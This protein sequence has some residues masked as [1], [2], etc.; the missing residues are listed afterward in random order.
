MGKGMSMLWRTSETFS[1]NAAKERPQRRQYSGACLSGLTEPK[2][3]SQSLY[4]NPVDDWLTI[5]CD[6]KSVRVEIY[7][8]KGTRLFSGTFSDK[9]SHQLNVSFLNTGVYMV[10]ISGKKYK[11]TS[12]N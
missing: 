5:P 8:L 12:N 1:G 7:D 2:E 10:D 11:G 9:D 6:G 4:P 3:N